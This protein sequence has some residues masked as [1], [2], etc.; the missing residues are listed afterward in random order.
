MQ[1]KNALKQVITV[2]SFPPHKHPYVK[3][4]IHN[5]HIPISHKFYYTIY[6]KILVL[7][8]NLPFISGR[9]LKIMGTDILQPEQG[10]TY[11]FWTFTLFLFRTFWRLDSSSVLR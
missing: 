2:I 8:N 10:A 6:L 5:L 7:S 9:A 3:S 4:P 11:K 1:E